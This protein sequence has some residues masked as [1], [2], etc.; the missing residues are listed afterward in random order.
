[1]QVKTLYKPKFVHISQGIEYA[2]IT[3]EAEIETKVTLSQEPHQN[4]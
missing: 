4:M 1:M 2:G 3:R